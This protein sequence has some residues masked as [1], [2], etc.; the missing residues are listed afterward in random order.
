MQKMSLATLPTNTSNPTYIPLS[1]PTKNITTATSIGISTAQPGAF[2][3]KLENLAYNNT[4]LPSAPQPNFLSGGS[5]GEALS[6]TQPLIPM[7]A[8][9]APQPS[10]FTPDTSLHS[11]LQQVSLLVN[12]LAR[13]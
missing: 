12:T 3:T 8:G 5:S 4:S 7:S 11:R 9:L 2:P 13:T 6:P 10:L 1:D